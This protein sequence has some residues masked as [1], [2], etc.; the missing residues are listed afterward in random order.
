MAL[1]NTTALGI[2]TLGAGGGLLLGAAIG[3]GL[4]S[5][6]ASEAAEQRKKE[7]QAQARSL[8]FNI[9]TLRI[10]AKQERIKGKLTVV[11]AEDELND[12]LAANLAGSFARGVSGGGSTTRV[13]EKLTRDNSFFDAITLYSSN[14]SALKLER[15][16]SFKVQQQQELI[17]EANETSGSL[18]G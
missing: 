17:K 14:I 18:F 9:G 10:D 11:L 2:A 12:A 4:D 8:G 7:L 13:Q 5:F 1:T 6:E 3:F 15:V 16:A